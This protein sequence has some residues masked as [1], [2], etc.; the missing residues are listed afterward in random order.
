MYKIDSE[1]FDQ[2]LLQFIGCV[3][4]L[5]T[6]D[7]YQ[8]S[9]RI[10]FDSGWLGEQEH[11][12]YSIW[13]RAQKI[14]QFSDWSEALLGK[15]IFTQK[16]IDCMNLPIEEG[17][18]KKQNL[19]DWHD[20]KYFE[21]IIS[22][23]PK[24]VESVLYQIYCA[25][26][27]ERAFHDAI[28]LFG[29]R[30]PLISF[31]FFLKKAPGQNV[32]CYLPVRPQTMNKRFQKLGIESDCLSDGC[33]WEHYQEYLQILHAVQQRLIYQLDPNAGLLD[34]HSFVWSMWVL[35][36][37]TP[38]EL[39]QQFYT[40]E[41]DLGSLQGYTRDAVIKAR[42]NQS[43]FRE[44][45]FDRYH[46]CRLC[47]VCNPALL[48]ASHIKPWA[49]SDP[50]EKLDVDNGFL[51]CPNHDR[52][53]DRGFISFEDSG[54]ILISKELSFYDWRSTNITDDMKIDL[55]EGNKVYL[56]YHREHIF[57]Y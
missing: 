42:V 46:R 33:T 31:L 11:Y 45:L 38:S 55:S 50:V 25:G 28:S 48:T 19:L 47:G 26:D 29:S 51:F 1:K 41:K 14:L 16:I 5:Q 8:Y 53:F 9:T 13:D 32:P 24:K 54:K 2:T 34:A 15:G 56:S 6:N 57:K 44:R 27:D 52:L 20:V 36:T 12:K 10:R 21:D 35:D 40:L 23:H 17:T 4:T 43:V 30:Y 49:N 22:R 3:L 18:T 37:V 39:P 7:H